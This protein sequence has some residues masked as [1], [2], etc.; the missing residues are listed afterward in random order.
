MNKIVEKIVQ[1]QNETQMQVSMRSI[2]VAKLFYKSQKHLRVS[3]K[4]KS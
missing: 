3:E 2:A 4:R 1:D